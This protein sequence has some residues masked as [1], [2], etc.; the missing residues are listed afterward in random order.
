MQSNYHRLLVVVNIYRLVKNGVYTNLDHVRVVVA[1]EDIVDS[2]L[3]VALVISDIK[4]APRKL[5]L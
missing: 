5:T 1:T 4:R 3:A 2:S